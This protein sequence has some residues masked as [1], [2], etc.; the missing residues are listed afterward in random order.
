M[1]PQTHRSNVYAVLVICFGIVTSFWLFQRKPEGAS[2]T[3]TPTNSLVVNTFRDIPENTNDDWKKILVN[4]D[5]KTQI[6]T[7]LTKTNPNAFDETTLTAQ[8]SK[9]FLSQYLLLKKGGKTLTQE[10][11][12]GITSNIVNSPVYTKTTGP[13]YIKTNLHIIPKSDTETIKKYKNTINLILKNRSMQVKENPTLILGTALNSE[14]E[15]VLKRLDPIVVIGKGMVSDLLS[16]EVPENAISVHLG[17]LNTSSNLL[18]NLEDMREVFSDPVR[19]LAG[20]GQYSKHVID[21]QN[22]LKNLNAYF[23]EKL[24]S[25]QSS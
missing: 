3:K 9:D 21:F 13:V 24:G 19:S 4:V 11:I 20:M 6:V 17:L 10:D 5:P 25:A 7:N 23:V 2:L 15:N 22:A 1:P 18:S 16:V 12:N 14:S 8:M